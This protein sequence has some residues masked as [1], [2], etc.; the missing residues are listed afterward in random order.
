MAVLMLA[1]FIV[2]QYD[3]VQ[4]FHSDIVQQ[5]VSTEQRRGVVSATA[6]V[7]GR[8]AHSWQADS[9]SKHLGR[10][11]EGVTR[12]YAGT[13]RTLAIILRK[14]PGEV[15]YLGTRRLFVAPIFFVPS[16]RLGGDV[17]DVGRYVGRMYIDTP[18][19]SGT[20]T[21]PGD[22]YISGGWLAI[23][24][25]ELAV[26]AVLACA[27]VVPCRLRSQRGWALY[28][29]A[30]G[31]FASAGLDWGSLTRSLLQLMVFYGPV[32]SLVYRK[33]TAFGKANPA[34]ALV[35]SGH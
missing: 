2:V 28:A 17:L 25:G 32:L 10:V 19:S 22:F 26:G 35:E 24:L 20:P 27:W 5:R 30:A 31:S 33:E 21:Q 7:L 34:S 23:A 6:Q 3:G 11:W 9:P 15:P 14:T 16:A 13:I 1:A 12:E 8:I 18:D 4:Q 29:I